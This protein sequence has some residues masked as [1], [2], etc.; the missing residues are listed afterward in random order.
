MRRTSNARTVLTDVGKLVLVVVG[1][2]VGAGAVLAVGV[3]VGLFAG[4]VVV[5]TGA[6][7]L[8]VAVAVGV[9]AGLAVPVG[10]GAV[11]VRRGWT[12]VETLSGAL[13]WLQWLD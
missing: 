3:V 2:V 12:D 7:P 5:E 9:A 13:D 11:A 8:G 10:L 4:R 1:T 6:V